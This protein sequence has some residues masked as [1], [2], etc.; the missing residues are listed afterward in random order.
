MT[1]HPDYP[2]P[3]MIPDDV[4]FEH[5]CE[6]CGKTESLTST[7]AYA[8]GWDYPPQMYQ[9]GVVSPRTCGRCGM[10]ATVWWALMADRKQLEDLTPEQLAT[11]DRIR[12]EIPD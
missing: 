3:R 1:V 7:E 8:A 6:V 10:D 9:W 2:D 12:N 5:V 4:P 11:V